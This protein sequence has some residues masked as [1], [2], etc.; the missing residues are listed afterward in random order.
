[1]SR[2]VKSHDTYPVRSMPAND[3]YEMKIEMT[4]NE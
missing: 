3:A 1:M 4:V 2:Q